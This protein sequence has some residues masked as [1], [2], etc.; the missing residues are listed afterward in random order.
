MN[1]LYVINN[2][3]LEDF[4]GY[5]GELVFIVKNHSFNHCT[6]ESTLTG[7]WWYADLKNDLVEAQKE[8][9]VEAQ[10]KVEIL[11]ESLQQ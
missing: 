3:H 1:N 4:Q 2:K 11:E 7:R 8:N 9:I 10:N 5:N 6:I